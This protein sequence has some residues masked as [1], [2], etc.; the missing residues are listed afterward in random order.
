MA[1]YTVTKVIDGDTLD[2]TPKRR[3]GGTSGKRVRLAGRSAHQ[4]LHWLGGRVARECVKLLPLRSG[5]R[6]YNGPVGAEQC[7]HGAHS[8][9]FRG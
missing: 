7:E 4:L 9:V 2:V 3:F 5:Y 6:T 1:T 8:L